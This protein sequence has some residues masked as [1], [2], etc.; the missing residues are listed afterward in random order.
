MNKT[1][2]LFCILWIGLANDAHGNDCGKRNGK[3]IKI[4]KYLNISKKVDET[5]GI[6][7]Y[8]GSFLTHNDSGGKPI[9]YRIDTLTGKII[10]KIEITNAKNKDWEDIAQDKDYIY[11]L[12]FL[13]NIV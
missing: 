7:I 1:I 4:N 5:S 3:K 9:L 8:Q 11:V 6:I 12:Y 10:G 2:L 13:N